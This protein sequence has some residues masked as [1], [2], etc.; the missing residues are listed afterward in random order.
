MRE[1]TK[2]DKKTILNE[3]SEE[4]QR[5][6]TLLFLY[7]FLYAFCID[8]LSFGQDF[9]IWCLYIII[10]QCLGQVFPGDLLLTNT[11]KIQDQNRSRREWGGGGC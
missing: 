4:V 2:N 9:K 3:G 7:D 6:I 11:H 5:E 10:N 1:K 8:P